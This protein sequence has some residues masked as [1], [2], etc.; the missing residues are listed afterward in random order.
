[1]ISLSMVLQHGYPQHQANKA[2]L[3]PSS[4]RSFAR[5]VE[6]TR[7]GD[8]ATSFEVNL[9]QTSGHLVK[10]I[11]VR[12]QFGLIDRHC[13]AATVILYISIFAWPLAQWY[14]LANDKHR[15]PA[16]PGPLDGATPGEGFARP[17]DISMEALICTAY[18]LCCAQI[19]HAERNTRQSGCLYLAPSRFPVCEGNCCECPFAC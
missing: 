16:E 12:S 1:M 5:S 4:S 11:S 19:G 9:S 14:L 17:T 8:M 3:W 13:E 10:E 2:V 6:H 7:G 15:H 18:R